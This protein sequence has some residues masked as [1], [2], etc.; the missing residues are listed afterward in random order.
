[1]V[2]IPPYYSNR[3]FSLAVIRSMR[4]GRTTVRV[5][6]FV[7]ILARRTQELTVPSESEATVPCNAWT[8]FHH[9]LLR[10]SLTSAAL[11]VLVALTILGSASAIVTPK[12]F[13][14]T[15]S[16]YF[17]PRPQE[18]Y[19]FTTARAIKAGLS[20]RNALGVA[21]LGASS[22]R[23]GISSD[24]QM[25]YLI[26]QQVEWPIAFFNLTASALSQYEM[27][28]LCDQLGQGFNGIVILGCSVFRMVRD[29]DE[30]IEWIM[31]P[32]VGLT[33]SWLDEEASI[34]NLT[35]P[36]P[37]GI[38]FLDQAGFFGVRMPYLMRNIIRGPVKP[39]IHNYLNRAPINNEE[40]ERR[41]EQFRTMRNAPDLPDP[42]ATE[43]LWLRLRDRL[44]GRGRVEVVLLNAPANPRFIDL[45]FGQE[46]Y[47]DYQDRMERFTKEND[48]HYWNIN[49]EASL[50]ESDFY[51]WA[52]ISNAEA[53]ERFTRILAHHVAQL[54]N[55]RMIEEAQP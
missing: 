25:A 34:L 53:Q 55:Q 52:H 43:A 37:T 16:P 48:M 28:A 27:V 54:L 31:R 23:E 36:R 10:P 7:N 3:L 22:H 1:M 44:R 33:S 29:P 41:V 26:Q 30:R 39:R 4:S 5:M 14:E 6:K 50:V 12:F 47:H 13:A 18:N 42:A 38:Y 11:T 24:Q 8:A 45:A 51:D 46:F 20:D 9:A 40:W 2:Q 19:T 35:R 49:D 17:A 21:V 32:R 15:A